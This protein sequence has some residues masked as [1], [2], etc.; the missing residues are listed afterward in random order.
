[1]DPIYALIEN[2]SY[3]VS[4]V[5]ASW[6]AVISCA[7]VVRGDCQ[8]K[9]NRI[10]VRRGLLLG[11]L[12]LT[13][14]ALVRLTQLMGSNAGPAFILP[15]SVLVFAIM[16]APFGPRAA[17]RRQVRMVAV[18]VGFWHPGRVVLG[19]CALVSV[20]LALVLWAALAWGA[21]DATRYRVFGFEESTLVNSSVTS[22]LGILIENF[23]RHFSHAPLL[24]D[25]FVDSHT[26][27]R[28]SYLHS[29]LAIL[30]H[31]GF[32]GFMLFVVML[33]AIRSQLRIAWGK[34]QGSPRDQR[35]VMFSIA[36]M[37]WAVMYV[38]MATFFT[39]GLLWF[40]I[41]LF[42]PAVHLSRAS[43]APAV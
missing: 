30:P 22:R 5:M 31:L 12:G 39:S 10:T 4:G 23:G 27:G 21:I 8:A 19:I 15:L 38:L 3:Q 28:G 33:I 34:A 36:A 26:T 13:L 32:V 43:R 41:G 2:E 6:I 24:G 17:I 11:M 9:P 20:A 14:A 35:F 18:K 7:A 40:V 1:M 16:L 42:V 37:S 29:L 25:M